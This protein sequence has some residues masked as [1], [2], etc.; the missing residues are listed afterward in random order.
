C[1]FSDNVARPPGASILPELLNV[2]VVAPSTMVLIGSGAAPASVLVAVTPH[3][4][5]ADF[6]K[7]SEYAIGLPSESYA[8]PSMTNSLAAPVAVLA[9]RLPATLISVDGLPVIPAP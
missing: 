1:M 5:L 3:V 2:S 9:S 4:L 7:C 8:V 6:W